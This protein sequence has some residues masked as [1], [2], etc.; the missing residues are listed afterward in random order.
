MS[1]INSVIDQLTR[2]RL[3]ATAGATPGAP[4][5]SDLSV[6]EY[7]LL[8]EAGFEPLGFV[9]GTSVYHVGIQIARWG[10]SQ[11]LTVL[12]QAMYSARELAM[13][14]M[15]AEAD[16]L[17]ADGIVGVSLEMQ[18]YAWGQDVFEF[19]ALG[20][21]VRSVDG[22]PGSHRAPNGMPFTSDLSAQDFYRLLFTG[23]IPVAFVLGTCVYHVAHQSAMQA[24]RQAGRNMEM[25]QFTQA[26]YTA[27]ELA[28]GRMQTEAQREQS[29]GIVGVRTNV[30]NHVWG[31]HAT[32]FLALGTAIRTAPQ[33]RDLPR[34][35]LVL[36][37]DR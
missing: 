4:F 32:E 5:T 13:E 23:S 15:V 33:P 19:V 17:Q 35:Q 24:L 25:P 6:S 18:R 2:G 29:D 27:R 9:V 28:L 34:P 10:V 30:L 36:G 1:D 14:R 3:S 11:E 16:L 12:T 26:V 21:A 31:E 8:K 37:L 20:T 22:P 7:L